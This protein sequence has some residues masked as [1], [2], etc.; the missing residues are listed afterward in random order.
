MVTR[1]VGSVIAAGAADLFQQIAQV[2]PRPHHFAKL[3]HHAK[4]QKIEPPGFSQPFAGALP[5]DGYASLAQKA[6][7][8]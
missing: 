1:P 5:K 2:L 4:N 7:Y 8:Q 3:M 6:G